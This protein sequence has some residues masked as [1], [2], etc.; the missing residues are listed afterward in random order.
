MSG[1]KVSVLFGSQLCEIER[2]TFTYPGISGVRVQ[3]PLRLSFALTVHRAQGSSLDKVVIHCEQMHRPG[4]L[5]VALGRAK[6]L[7][8]IQIECFS[9]QLKIQKQ[10][11]EVEYFYKNAP[12]SCTC[13][14]LDLETYEFVPDSQD[15]A[16]SQSSQET[17]PQDDATE[18]M[19]F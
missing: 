19:K 18:N 16:A 6:K 10:P 14:S 4:Q 2:A 12:A 5:G 1:N 7:S 17:Q 3:F 15:T 8:G 11:E 13:K 9:N